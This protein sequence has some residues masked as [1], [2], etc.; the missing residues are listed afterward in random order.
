MPWLLLAAVILGAGVH[1]WITRS[2]VGVFDSDGAV[3]G[4]MARH[5]RHGEMPAFFWGQAYGGSIEPIAAGVL[6][7]VLGPSVWLL[8]AV[9]LA[10]N[11]ASMLLVWRIGKRTVGEPAARIGAVLLWIWSASFL[12]WSVKIDTYQASLFL[13]LLAMLLLLRLAQQSTW[14]RYEAGVLGLVVGLAFW[15]NVQTA[16]IILPAFVVHLGSVLRRWSRLPFTAA[17]FVVGAVPWIAFNARN[18][19]S[20]LKPP[21]AGPGNTYIS[22][23][24]G[25]F[26]FG[27]PEAFG[28]RTPFTR[29]W[30]LGYGGRALYGVLLALFAAAVVLV[31]A[32]RLRGGA[33]LVLTGVLYPFL[34]ALSP[35][36][37]YLD[38]PRYLLFLTPAVGLL[39]GRLLS[40]IP[41]RPL[42]VGAAL[43]A[44]AVASLA[45]LGQMN[46]GRMTSPFAPDR[47]QPTSFA[48]LT[49]LLRDY[50]VRYA[51]A[52]YWISYRAMFEARERTAVTPLLIV[53]NKAIDESVRSSPDPAY[54]FLAASKT[55]T[56]FEQKAGAI[57]ARITT[58]I[59]G[60]FAVVLPDRKVLPEQLG[61]DWS[62][63]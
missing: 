27:L 56:D 11:A 6:F 38:H 13:A 42:A 19:L 41:L 5:L 61:I 14:S 60:D 49:S 37:F 35:L 15:A 22:R 62:K 10:F 30:V 39:L 36:S 58:A 31:V 40:A 28:L 3:P 8:K 52:D 47:R 53:R 59:K 34:F 21:P 50:H 43:S 33:A 46:A 45:A 57:G 9:P 29:R 26:R 12:W 16:Y 48:D 18:H 24:Q 25:F 2:P 4:L 44:A 17:A 20:S 23:L 32:R 7:L 63:P 55:R 51:F 54:I 1:L